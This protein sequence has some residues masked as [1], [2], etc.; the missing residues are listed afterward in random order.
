MVFFIHIIIFD[1]DAGL[2]ATTGATAIVTETGNEA[3]TR[4]STE[5]VVN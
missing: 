2:A 4:A 3:V 1:S 5:L